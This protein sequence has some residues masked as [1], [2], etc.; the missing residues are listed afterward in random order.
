[1]ASTTRI[2][3]YTDL[4]FVSP[5]IA[6]RTAAGYG[7]FHCE[8]YGARKRPC[9]CTLRSEPTIHRPT[10]N[11]NRRPVTS[12]A[13][14]HVL[15]IDGPILSL[16]PPLPHSMFIYCF[17]IQHNKLLFLD[18]NLVPVRKSLKIESLVIAD[19]CNIT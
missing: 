19:V 11:T 15:L 8:E 12:P 14:N 18:Y 7:N 16:I 1:M 2:H 17:R 3:T 13:Q 4:S 5:C 9:A 10:A 6:S